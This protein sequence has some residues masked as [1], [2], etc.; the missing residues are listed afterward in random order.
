MYTTI[1]VYTFCGEFV[2]LTMTNELRRVGSPY[3]RFEDLITVY[4]YKSYL[5]VF[6]PRKTRLPPAVL[7]YNLGWAGCWY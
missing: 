3:A 7:A 1:T 4:A 2:T 6:V 5:R